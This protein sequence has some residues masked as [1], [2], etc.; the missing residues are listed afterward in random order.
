MS[1]RFGDLRFNLVDEAIK[2]PLSQNRF[3]LNGT[4]VYPLWKYIEW[5]VVECLEFFPTCP[6]W[7]LKTKLLDY[8]IITNT[9][10]WF[11]KFIE[12][13]EKRSPW[14]SFSTIFDSKWNI[15]LNKTI[16]RWELLS[17]ISKVLLEDYKLK[18]EPEIYNQIM[19]E[20][21]GYQVSLWTNF[22]KKPWQKLEKK[23]VRIETDLERPR[24]G[25]ENRGIPNAETIL[26]HTNK[27]VNA[28]EIYGKNI[29]WINLQKFMDMAYIHDFPESKV[30]DFVPWEIEKWEK[31]IIEYWVIKSIKKEMGLTWVM[32]E[33]LWLEYE[34]QKTLEAQTLIQLDKLDAAIQAMEYEDMWYTNVTD[35]YDYTL[36]NL[37][38]PVLK[39]ILL[40]LM[41]NRDKKRDIYEQYYEL[42]EN[43]WKVAI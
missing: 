21:V 7:H 2:N 39:K 29:P 43:N 28:A 15:D 32:I 20:I 26:Q 37:T 18:A 9:F 8:W 12:K 38:D 42:L 41:N 22:Y 16:S 36:K 35:F 27:L 5:R 3:N 6:L 34:E 23:F 24:S 11:E 25:W 33:K 40:H 13:V 10:I 30:K 31:F 19:S 14:Y 17:T 4:N 1:N